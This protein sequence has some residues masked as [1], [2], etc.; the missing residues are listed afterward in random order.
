[1]TSISYSPDG[2]DLASIGRHTDSS[3]H[4]ED[5][6]DFN[7]ERYY[8]SHKLCGYMIRIS[9]DGRWMASTSDDESVRLYDLSHL[10]ASPKAATS[11]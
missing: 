9:P 3:V 5:T 8:Q 2:R 6:Q 11:N 10:P 7:V 1:V 4:I